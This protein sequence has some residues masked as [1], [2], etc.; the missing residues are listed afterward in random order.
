MF[1]HNSS[2]RISNKAGFIVESGT[3][4]INRPAGSDNFELFPS[5]TSGRFNI[6]V[7]NPD[8]NR[9]SLKISSLAGIVV[10]NRR[11]DRAQDIDRE[12]FDLSAIPRGIYII[13]LHAGDTFSLKKLV[14]Q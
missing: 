11:Y 2:I 10:L 12:E 3:T 9:M 14:L 5:I 6:K 1:I 8:Q 13:M 4:G 7:S